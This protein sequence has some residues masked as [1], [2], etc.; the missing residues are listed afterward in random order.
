MKYINISHTALNIPLQ[1][2]FICKGSY[3]RHFE[4][5]MAYTVIIRLNVCAVNTI[6]NL[7]KNVSLTQNSPCFISFRIIINRSYYLV[8]C[9]N[10]CRNLN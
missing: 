3:V 7:N 10:F 4:L 2:Y 8:T 1:Y 9:G 6:E 5:A